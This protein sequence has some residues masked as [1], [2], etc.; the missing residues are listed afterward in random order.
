[1]SEKSASRWVSKLVADARQ[2]IVG[3]LA[4]MAVVALGVALLGVI[5][6]TVPVWTL[7]LPFLLLLPAAAVISR[8]QRKIHGLA[9]ELREA[10]RQATESRKA[11]VYY[12]QQLDLAAIRDGPLDATAKGFLR[13]IQSLRD[14]LPGPD[15]GRSMA[16]GAEI[17]MV[18]SLIND[19][20]ETIGS[21]RALYTAETIWRSD[22]EE[23]TPENLR[24]TLS[25]L[26]AL[27]EEF[28]LKQGEARAEA[29]RQ[30]G[31]TF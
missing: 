22:Y 5:G 23:Q 1:V 27:V 29:E 3:G 15:H 6:G 14:S 7:G 17:A 11:E 30:Q 4:F 31:S 19:M 9:G 13:R 28:G 10:R 21:S 16:N 25:Q 18:Q 20:R 2:G 8:L 12:R 26:E 24:L